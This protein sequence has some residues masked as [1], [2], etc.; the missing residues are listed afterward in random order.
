[1][2]EPSTAA[3]RACCRAALNRIR[4]KHIKEF[5]GA[6]GTV[7]LISDAYPGVWME[8]TYDALAWVALDASDKA[9]AIRQT[10]LFLD[11]QSEEGQFPFRFVDISNPHWNGQPQPRNMNHMQ[12]CVSFARMCLAAHKLNPGS[13]DYLAAAYEACCR[14]D[15]WMV[16]HRMQTGRGL[17]EMYCGYDTGH[18]N[19]ERLRGMKYEGWVGEDGGY[20]P[21]DCPVAPMLA[22]DMNANFYGNRVAL[23]EMAALL[24]KPD[25]AA[26]WRKKANNIREKMFELLFD[27]KDCFFYDV[28][29]HGRQRRMKSISITNVILEDVCDEA[30]VD[31]IYERHFKNPAAFGTPYPFPSLAMNE[32]RTKPHLPGNDWGYYSMGL[33]ALRTLLWMPRYGRTKEMHEMMRAWLRGWTNCFDTMPFGQE[34]DPYAGTPSNCSSWYSATML[35][36]LHAARELGI[37][38]EF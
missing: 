14:R 11:R 36:Y 4:T 12:E 8:H 34:L 27:E 13:E 9:I 31:E 10:R 2:K 15:R 16:E 25:E 20:M 28:D 26:A 35:Y 32:P 19:S 38:D 6:S 29:K 37:F 3:V 18:D 7:F 21:T 5:P 22:T 17:I 1:M 24:G 30:L 23:S 33:T